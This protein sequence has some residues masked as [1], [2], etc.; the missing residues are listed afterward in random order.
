MSTFKDLGVHA[1]FIKAL[2]ENNI[3]EPSEIQKK[4]IPY[5]LK[6][7]KDFIGQAQTGTGKTA[8]FGLPLLHRVNPK[9][10][11]VQALVLA[12]TRE[13]CQQIAKQ[14]FRF[15]KYSAKIFAESVYG[16]EKID[17]QIRALKRPTQIVVATPGRLLDLLEKK[18]IDLA[19]IQT[20][21]LDEADEMLSMG[22]KK[23][24]DA[25]LK[26]TAGDRHTW[27]FSATMPSGI[28]Q[29]IKT[30]MAPDAQRIEVK[31]EDVVNKSIQHQY[32]VCEQ[33]QKLDI[34]L[35]FL[36]SQGDKMGI[37]FCRTKAATQNLSL[38]LQSK[39]V[40]TGAIHGDLTQKERDKVMRAFRKQNLKV[41]VAT[42]ISARGIDVEGLGYVIHFQ[43]PDQIDYYT[44]RSGRTARAGKKGLSFSIL[45]QQEV[46]RIDQFSK[47]LNIEFTE[48][49][50]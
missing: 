48:T 22:F 2:K 10:K 31:K 29:I 8:A 44:H 37:I 47:E 49:A 12:P 35:H 27:L 25:I 42:D 1:D 4:S 17:I 9:N 13:L 18:A 20:L 50:G 24:L 38:Q 16:G 30:Y 46:K 41:L 28:H 23:E 26:F 14:L 7:G 36:S 5:L 32:V 39:N 33:S 6:E 11:Q 15:T 21:V 3:F 34:L 43:L 19:H 45:T 40:A